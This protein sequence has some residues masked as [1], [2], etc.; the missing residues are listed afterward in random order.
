VT[1]QTVHPAESDVMSFAAPD[2]PPLPARMGWLVRNLPQRMRERPFWVIQGWV[3]GITAAHLLVEL[4]A[5]TTNGGL[6]PAFHHIPVV[7][8]LGPISYASLRYGLEGAVLTGLWSA[9]LTVPNIILQHMADFEWLTE[10]AYVGI[11]VSV[12][13]VMAIPVERE[14]LQ[15]RR[16]EAN[17][18]R[19]A[20]LRHRLRAYAQ[21]V[22]RAQE[23]E[24]RR[25][26]RELHDEAAQNLVAIR[27]NLDSL[28]GDLDTHA[29]V[30]VAR[31]QELAGKTLAGLRR[32]SRDLRP[33]ML[34]DLGLVSAL[35]AL[36]TDVHRRTGLA[37]ELAVTGESRRLPSETELALYRIG[38]GAL[39][40]VERHAH[41][42]R[43]SI[44]VT[45]DL[46]CVRLVV[47][48]DGDGFELPD[49]LEDLTR[50]GKLGL[51]GMSE[52][53]ELVGGRLEI[54]SAPG[55][56]TRV[57]VET[58]ASGDPADDPLDDDPIDDAADDPVDRIS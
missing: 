48:D 50:D 31:T 52:R 36:V 10:L 16:A 2:A 11:I 47:C 55:A 46:T 38:Q 33:P 34:D 21:L 45:Y 19:L 30:E 23:D 7:L 12:G 17:S 20:R 41:A 39:H 6:Q 49:N 8:Y 35:E 15:R 29:A 1:A 13:V 56:G 53:A 5:G 51:V 18:Q 32:F 22:V 43:V 9:V 26:A 24:R 57:C 54:H 37:V 40:N 28:V 42:G 25:I 44:A 3:V 4:W 14:R 27:R 58:P